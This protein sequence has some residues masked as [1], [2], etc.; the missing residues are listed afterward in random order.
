MS[1]LSGW[2]VG[3][4]L[5]NYPSILTNTFGSAFLHLVTPAIRTTM[6]KRG[7]QTNKRLQ[8]SGASNP[9][10][11]LKRATKA[12]KAAKQATN[13]AEKAKKAK[14]AKKAAERWLP[15]RRLQ[16]QKP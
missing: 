10:K 6:T 14:E 13:K 7:S 2:T 16:R 12:E 4:G 11:A 1:K 9:H 8:A 3:C 15:R 5:S